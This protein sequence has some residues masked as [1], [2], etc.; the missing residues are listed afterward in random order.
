MQFKRRG[1]TVRVQVASRERAI[2]RHGSAA[3]R[4]EVGQFKF[5]AS[6][7]CVHNACDDGLPKFPGSRGRGG[8]VAL[9]V[10]RR[11]CRLTQV[12]HCNHSSTTA[13]LYI[14]APTT[15]PTCMCSQVINTDEAPSSPFEEALDSPLP[16]S[17]PAGED[18]SQSPSPP[19]PPSSRHNSDDST[20]AMYDFEMGSKALLFAMELLSAR[21]PP[22]SRL[23]PSGKASF[24][25]TAKAASKIIKR[26]RFKLSC[27]DQGSSDFSASR[28]P[29]KRK[30]SMIE[31]DDPVAAVEC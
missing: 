16:G 25:S 17:S 31:Q 23:V 9:G 18:R 10:V 6:G 24:G 12:L 22:P 4:F 28:V 21:P 29:Q 30:S 2:N 5:C 3:V 20:A 26:V 11:P 13:L 1:W 27:S 15:S 7:A 19:P 14:A 8:D